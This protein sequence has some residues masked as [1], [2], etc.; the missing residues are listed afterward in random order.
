MRLNNYSRKKPAV[1]Y[2]EWRVWTKA[3]EVNEVREAQECGIRLAR[4][5]DFD[6]GDV[7]EC[8]QLEEVE[9]TL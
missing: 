9:Q 4:F 2:I 6:E 1:N 5:S 8:Y 7:L 3:S